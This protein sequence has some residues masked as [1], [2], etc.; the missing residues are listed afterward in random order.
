MHQKTRPNAT[1]YEGKLI[2]IHKTFV[3]KETS[4][5]QLGVTGR[6]YLL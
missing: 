5:L 2:D 3:T 6:S 1:R 4:V